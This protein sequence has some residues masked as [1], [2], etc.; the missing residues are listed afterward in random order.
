LRRFEKGAAS[1]ATAIG[2]VE[3]LSGDGGG[4]EAIESWK[5]AGREKIM[6]DEGV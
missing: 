4:E 5:K 3:G 1:T 6:T 2:E